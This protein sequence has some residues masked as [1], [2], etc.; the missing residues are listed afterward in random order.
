[1]YAHN[2]SLT[3]FNHSKR[4]TI[5]IYLYICHKYKTI[6]DLLTLILIK[7]RTTMMKKLFLWSALLMTGFAFYSC[8]DAIDN[9][10]TGKQDPSNPNATWTYEVGIKFADF[11]F[12]SG[13]D[14]NGNPT[15]YYK[16]ADG[17]NYVYKAPS[18]VFVYNS[19]Y[20]KL[21]TL[22]RVEEQGDKF[23]GKL[24]G[25]IGDELIISS[26]EDFDLYSKQDGTLK[27]IVDNCI[28]Q[29]ATVPIIVT[30]TNT[31]KIGTQ[32][33]RMENQTAVVPFDFDNWARKNDRNVTISA[34]S[35]AMGPAYKDAKK[36]FSFII[37]DEI[38]DPTKDWD[39]FFF[40][41][42]FDSK[43]NAKYTFTLK[44]DNGYNSV[45]EWT[46][47]LNKGKTFEQSYVSMTPT[48]L[49]LTKYT[50][51]LK[52][53]VNMEPPYS[54]SIQTDNNGEIEP[55]IYQSSKDTVEVR[56]TIYGKATIKDLVIGKSGN[57]RLQGYKYIYE[58]YTPVAEYDYLPVITVIGENSITSTNSYSVAVWAEAT[59]KGDGTLKAE[60]KNRGIYITN[61]Y[62]EQTADKNWNWTTIYKPA[63]LIVTDNVK[64]ISN[65]EIDIYDTW[66]NDKYV[67]N[68]LILK[69]GS[70]E[71][72]GKNNQC[73]IALWGGKLTIGEGTSV[74]A[75][76]GM[77]GDNAIY[78]YDSEKNAEA[79]IESLV[80]D[81]TKF[82]D[83]TKDGVRTIK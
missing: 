44:S 76:T 34:D 45:G 59:L 82:T 33:V 25:A 73:A 16:D 47:L 65:S 78:I 24:T 57:L 6:C 81:K 40:A 14:A 39:G 63:K 79:T 75:T 17:N 64:L 68:E 35:L 49:D 20:E 62:Y 71:A 28:L 8:D 11:V 55:I 27:S 9:P 54:I 72:K 26:L 12:A 19:A 42:A 70:L 3:I 53:E 69:G 80:D 37:S 43:E 50:A 18:T 32:N 48:E 46:R 58:S 31:G 23:A 10:V 38:E 30:N 13:Y 2:Y 61:S 7:N 83:E 21:G 15:A 60:A 29:T 74:K 66:I 51:Y 56:L 36:A 52:N 5:N 22:T 77:T 41:V 67:A 4:T 1:M